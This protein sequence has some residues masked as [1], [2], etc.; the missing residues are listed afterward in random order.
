M[1]TVCFWAILIL[2]CTSGCSSLSVN[3][4]RVVATAYCNCAQCCGWQRGSSKF[5]HLD[6]W[7][8]TVADGPRAG[9]K[10]DGKTASGT[11]PRAPQPGLFSVDSITKPWMIPTRAVFFPWK[12]VPRKGTIAADTKYYPIGTEI[13][14][15]GYGWGVVE[16]RGSAIQGPERI[17]VYFPSH[18]RALEWGKQELVIEVKSPR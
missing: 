6:V 2:T 7:N 15:P 12:G 1:R 13:Y 4:K 18:Q 3:E 16:D 8:R 11:K 5:L 10:Y 9:R 14:V 17:D